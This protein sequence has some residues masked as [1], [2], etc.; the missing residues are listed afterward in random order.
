MKNAEVK[1]QKEETPKTSDLRKD[2][3]RA[4]Q[5]FAVIPEVVIRNYGLKKTRFM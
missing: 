2:P 1:A 3:S 4:V 5:R